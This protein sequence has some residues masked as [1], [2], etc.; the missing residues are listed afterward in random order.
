MTDI[1]A[2]VTIMFWAL[3]PLFWIPV[4]G[5][6]RFFKRLGIFTYITPFVT[7]L[8]VVWLIY[9]NRDLLLSMRLD[10]PLMVRAAGC[11]IFG[12]GLLLQIWTLRLLSVWG[13]VGLPEV[14]KL[15]EGRIIRTGPFSV[16]RHPTYVSHT[17]MFAGVFF[18]T[19][20]AAIGAITLLDL[21]IVNVFVIPLEDRELIE[22]FGTEYR[23]YKEQVP[24]YFPR[25]FR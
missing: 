2:L 15:V 23:T 24:A 12:F 14:T 22:R 25:L 5:L 10:L 18:I 8:P 21:L 1:L 7:W 3:V 9:I 11:V 16:I 13:I 19:G 4:H 17:V 6:S 20:V